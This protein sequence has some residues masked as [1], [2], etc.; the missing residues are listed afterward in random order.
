[1]KLTTAGESHGKGLFAIIEGMPAHLKIDVNEINAQLS[2]RQGGYGR[3]ARQQIEKDA[4]EVLSGV[5]NGESIGSPITLAV[6]NRDYEN[7][8]PYMDAH[9]CDT[10]GKELTAVRP[11]HADLAGMIKYGYQDARV[12]SER[13]SARETAI[14]VASGTIARQYLRTLGVQVC[15]YVR[16]VGDIKDDNCYTFDQLQE[17]RLSP[18]FML[19][20]Q[21]EQEAMQKI[22]DLQRQG[23]TVGGVF[24]VRVHGLKEG[25][26]SCMQYEDKLDAVLCSALM[27]IQA[28]KGVEVGLGFELANLPGSQAQDEIYYKDGKFYRQTNRAGGIEG[29]MSNGEDIVL[30]AVMKPIPTTAKGIKTVDYSTKL[31]TLSA[32]ERADVCAIRSALVVAESVVCFALAQMVDKRLGGDTMA[33]VKKR[34]TQL[35]EA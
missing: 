7:W 8:Q 20:K 32:T 12:I 29:G 17:D 22:D 16:Q 35:N 15:G 27:S 26:G 18:L 13:A 30:R 9:S 21:K 5:R 24:E 4:V 11:G 28:I 23:D 1:M 19:D 33:Q 34:Y 6:Y 3:G 10:T 31:A 14:R 2:L 25:F